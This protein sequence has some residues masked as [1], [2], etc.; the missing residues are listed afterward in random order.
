MSV[1]ITL[2]EGDPS[3]E[4]AE[5]VAALPEPAQAT[6][7]SL[8]SAL[9]EALSAARGRAAPTLVVPGLGAGALS[10]QRAAEVLLEVARRAPSDGALQEI[11]FVLAG[12]PLYRI[13]EMVN[14]AARVAE[15]M[16]KLRQRRGT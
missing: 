11:R 13:Y 9:R 2:R 4:R 3:A 5:L 6:E 16:A 14:D 10:Q 7:E 8:R 12:E 15:Q 1:R